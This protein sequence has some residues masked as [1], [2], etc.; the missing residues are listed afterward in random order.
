VIADVE[1]DA[2][3]SAI[4]TDLAAA[5][6]AEVRGTPTIFMYRDGEY[7]TNASGPV[8]FDVVTRVLGV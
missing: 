6:A 7:Q 5:D 1:S 3:Q 2:V 8:S 4:D